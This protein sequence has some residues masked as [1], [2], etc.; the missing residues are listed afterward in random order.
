MILRD[1]HRVRHEKR[2]KLID[3]VK[4]VMEEFLS[5]GVLKSPDVLALDRCLESGLS[6]LLAEIACEGAL[7]GFTLK[8]LAE[9]PRPDYPVCDLPVVCKAYS[10]TRSL[11]GSMVY[12][13]D[14]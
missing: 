8:E 1:A 10:H 14:L 13:R 4:V 3:V 6:D 7:A 11:S 12:L 5:S 9:D 2:S